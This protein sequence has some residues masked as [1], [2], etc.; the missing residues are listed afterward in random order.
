MANKLEHVDRMQ[1]VRSFVGGEDNLQM[2]GTLYASQTGH[3]VGGW[4]VNSWSQF[5]APY[6]RPLMHW[7]DK[8]ENKFYHAYLDLDRRSMNLHSEDKEIEPERASFIRKMLKKWEGEW[9]QDEA[10][11]T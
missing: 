6:W 3:T 5:G 10:K 9:L 2:W 1:Q 7:F 4:L 11:R 8:G